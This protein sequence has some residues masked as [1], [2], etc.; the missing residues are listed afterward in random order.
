[1]ARR[2]V[3]VHAHPDDETLTCGTTMA[4]HVARGDEV[5]VVTCTLGEEGEVIPAHLSELEG[6]PDDLLAEHRRGE[7]AAA[8]DALGATGHLLGHDGLGR[9]R[10]RDSGMAG[11]AAAVRRDAFVNA[12]LTEAGAALAGLLRELRPDVVVTYD[13]QGGYSHPDHIQAHRL[14]RAA[15]DQLTDAELPAHTYE[16][17]TPRTWAQEDRA[18]TRGASPAA[19]GLVVAGEDDPYPPSVVDDALVTHVVEDAGTRAAKLA[20]L[21]AHATQVIVATDDLHALSNLIARRTTDRE[22]FRRVD[23]RTW[24]PSPGEAGERT[25]RP[26][27]G[28]VD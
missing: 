11:S 2:L 18:W 25:E 28:L 12:D 21:R 7:L 16:I 10:Y 5:H 8:L 27:A 14:T 19:Y 26:A 22:G 1:M 3:L 6:H 17:L 13:P 24:E 20:A 23:P 4:H 15:L 9:R